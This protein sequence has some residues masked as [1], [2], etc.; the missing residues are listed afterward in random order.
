M[1]EKILKLY[2]CIIS[3]LMLI[4]PAYSDTIIVCQ[5]GCNYS[6]IQKA[7]NSANSGDT[8]EVQSGTYYENVFVSRQITLK[9]VDTG[10]GLPIVD[11]KGSGSAIT[12]TA[13]GATLEGFK[14]TKSGTCGCGNAGIR[15]MSN[16]STIFDNTAYGNKYGIYCRNRIGNK[17]FQNNLEDNDINAYDKG[18]NQWSENI[19]NSSEIA[20]MIPRLSI[21]GNYYSDFDKASLG[22]SDAN[23]DGICDSSRKIKG[24]SNEDKYPLT[25]HR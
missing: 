5:N 16:N 22:C 1:R 7:I 2:L 17:I 4:G 25:S 10:K 24:G 8:V 20:K 21:V 12:L 18:N 6:S 23:V 15:I 13:D 14:V 19:G 11:A 3:I 9:G